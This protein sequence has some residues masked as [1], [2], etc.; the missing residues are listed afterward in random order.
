VRPSLLFYCQHSVGL[1]HL[2]RSH[3]LCAGLADRFR[4]VLACGG[5]LPEGIDPPPDVE[6]VA[7]PPLGVDPEAGFVSRDP[8]FTLERARAARR[9]LLL[10]TLRAVR[11]RAVLVE[12]FPFG[13]AKFAA[14]LVPL[15]E[16]ARAGGALTA[17]S[18]RDILVTRRANQRAHDDRACA[19]AN[20]HLD[21][22]LV[23][24]D[25]AFARIEDTFAPSRPLA[26]PVHYT[27][28]V[29]GGGAP[30]PARRER[31]VVVSAGGGLVGEPLLR[32]AVEARPAGLKMRVIAGPLLPE[33]AWRRL[34][35][36]EQPGLELIRSVP[37]L[38][39]ELRSAA[40]SVSQSGYNTAL[41][42]V[43]SRVPALV[44]PYV[45]DEED[46]QLRRARRLARLGALRVLERLDPDALASELETLASF[47]PAA[48]ALDLDGARTTSELLSGLVSGRA[49]A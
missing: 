38:G 35:A 1:G 5:P 48:T 21:A 34:K 29:V 36:R 33:P 22:V 7:L 40:A 49:A 27:G 12:L 41:E 32:A 15:L 9:E 24:S 37:D 17:C 13:R 43:R 31:H 42:I 16:A 18:L 26:V 19:L 11:P 3:A 28:F 47:R 25:P 39:E 23:H 30:P 44:V 6:V 4:V 45:T 20:A 2:T 14:E 46:E 8:R 10:R